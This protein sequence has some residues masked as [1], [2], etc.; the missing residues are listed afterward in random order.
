MAEPPRRGR[1]RL[2]ERQS[3]RWHRLRNRPLPERY[4]PE[5][6]TPP[7]R[8]SG[9]S[10]RPSGEQRMINDLWYKNAIIYCLSVGAYMDANGTGLGHFTGPLRPPPYLH[11]LAIPA[12]RAD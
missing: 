8:F 12:A 7:V 2:R 11:T 9:G 4:I 3:P 5:R 1:P 6:K 10:F